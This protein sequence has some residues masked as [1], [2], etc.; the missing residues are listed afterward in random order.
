MEILPHLYRALDWMEVYQ[1]VRTPL[2]DI[3]AH[4]IPKISTP[5][6]LKFVFEAYQCKYIL[7][8]W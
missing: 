6:M 4:A 7:L 1:A 3:P 2:P 5:Q 8:L